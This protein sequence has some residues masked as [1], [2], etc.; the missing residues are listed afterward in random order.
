[1]AKIVL[2]GAGG[3]GWTRTPVTEILAYPGL[4]DGTIGLVDIHAGRSVARR[5]KSERY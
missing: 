4:R 2:I 3:L 5:D 1:M